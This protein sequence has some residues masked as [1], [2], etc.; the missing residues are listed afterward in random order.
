MLS[1]PR[2]LCRLTQALALLALVASTGALGLLG[3][4]RKGGALEIMLGIVAVLLLIGACGGLRYLAQLR[5]YE[6]PEFE[7]SLLRAV[8]GGLVFMGAIYH[9]SW[10]METFAIIHVSIDKL[11]PQWAGHALGLA[12]GVLI[13]LAAERVLH[14]T[15]GADGFHTAGR[16]RLSR[17]RA[18]RNTRKSKGGLHG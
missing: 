18:G 15:P 13:L 6:L 7:A 17:L 14:H 10:V 4:V 3:G 2:L 11:L 12:P 1:Q 9:L 16:L 5:A 8:V